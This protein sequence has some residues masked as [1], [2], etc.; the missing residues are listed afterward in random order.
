MVT[1][2]TGAA[3]EIAERWGRRAHVVPHPHVVDFATM[4]RLALRS[5]P[6]D[7]VRIGLHVKSLRASMDPGRLLP[8]LLRFVEREPRHGGAGERSP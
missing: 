2:T 4:E 6:T 5:R 1:L 7:E 3:Q 8:T